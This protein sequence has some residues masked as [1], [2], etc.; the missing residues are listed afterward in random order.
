MFLK[1]NVD[2][3]MANDASKLTLVN[4]LA[5]NSK[6]YYEHECFLLPAKMRLRSRSEPIATVVLNQ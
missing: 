1:D 3:L 4:L 2:V 5:S 6:A